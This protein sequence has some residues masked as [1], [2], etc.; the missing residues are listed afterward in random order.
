MLTPA[1]NILLSKNSDS[2]A[3]KNFDFVTGIR[4]NGHERA[5]RMVRIRGPWGPRP[6]RTLRGQDG[7]SVAGGSAPDQRQPER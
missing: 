1:R 6:Q 7:V 3:Y 2:N 4:R 5:A